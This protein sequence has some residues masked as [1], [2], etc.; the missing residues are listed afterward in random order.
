M[1][2]LLFWLP[3]G[4]PRSCQTD[5]G[6]YPNCLGWWDN[7]W[8]YY[9]RLSSEV[10]KLPQLTQYQLRQ[11]IG[12]SNSY[13]SSEVQPTFAISQ[14]VRASEAKLI[15][16][17]TVASGPWE[18]GL[19]QWLQVFYMQGNWSQLIKTKWQLNSD[20]R[21]ELH[22]EVFMARLGYLCELLQGVLLSHWADKFTNQWSIGMLMVGS[23]GP[24]V[25]WE[26]RA[27]QKGKIFVIL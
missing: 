5:D 4:F 17:M 1:R 18:I 12:P 27:F 26:G 3:L 16:T 23:I 11:P 14:F 2:F 13:N 21:N 10:E 15:F 25:H 7:P 24:F 9:L 19:T 8:I 20:Q 6:I 22:T